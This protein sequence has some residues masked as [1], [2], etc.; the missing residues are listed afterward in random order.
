MALQELNRICNDARQQFVGI[1]HIAICHRLGL[2]FFVFF[3][4]KKKKKPIIV[5]I[6]VK[7]EQDSIS[8]WIKQ[9]HKMILAHYFPNYSFY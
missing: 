4:S 3:S 6:F 8:S 5:K 2:A 9:K 7:F 1:K